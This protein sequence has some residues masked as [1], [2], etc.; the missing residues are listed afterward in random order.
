[1]FPISGQKT[2]PLLILKIIAALLFL[3][4]LYNNKNISLQHFK[5]IWSNADTL[6]IGV[7][8]I[9]SI[10]LVFLNIIHWHYF[11]KA[12]GLETT[13][14][15]STLTY[16]AGNLFGLVS[17]GR[18][19]EFGRGYLYKG[20]SLKDTALVTLAEKF[21]FVFFTVLFGLIGLALGHE[22]IKEIIHLTAII[23][24]FIL[25]FIVLCVCL[26]ILIKGNKI[27]F[28]GL[29]NLFPGTEPER[30][31]LLTLT[32]LTYILMV[33][34]FYFILISFL[35]IKMI[36]AFITLSLTLVVITFFPISF[37]NLGVREA[38]FIYLL[39]AAA[40]FPETAA[41]NAGFLVFAEN[42][43]V[44]SIAGLIVVIITGKTLRVKVNS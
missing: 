23:I 19:A 24:A 36:Y 8:F 22:L 13:Y 30:F 5:W 2:W 33:I 40:G 4:Y 15:Q 26:L 31:F 10:I 29:F 7:S 27:K 42:I 37:G 21:Y 38:C 20:H 25:L 35:K 1:M 18:L 32:N 3:Y 39:N 11:M 9:I 28:K 16:L 12:G 34:Q 17:P 43:L 44:P 6:Y 14:R 41:L